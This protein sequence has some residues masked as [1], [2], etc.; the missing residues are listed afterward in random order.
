MAAFHGSSKVVDHL[1]GVRDLSWKQSQACGSAG[2]RF[3]D[4]RTDL[5][6]LYCDLQDLEEE[7]TNPKTFFKRCDHHTEVELRELLEECVEDL[8]EIEDFINALPSQKRTSIQTLDGEV[9]ELQKKICDRRNSFQDFQEQATT[10]ALE[11]MKAQLYTLV[12]DILSKR[13]PPFILTKVVDW[14]ALADELQH[15]VLVGRDMLEFD[16]GDAHSDDY[17]VIELPDSPAAGSPDPPDDVTNNDET[18]RSRKTRNLQPTVEDYV[19]GE[20]DVFYSPATIHTSPR[21]S[22]AGVEVDTLSTSLDPPE[23]THGQNPDGATEYDP[24]ADPKRKPRRVDTEMVLMQEQKSTI[25]EEIRKLKEE[26][27]ILEEQ[28]RIWEAEQ[29]RREEIQKF[30]EFCSGFPKEAEEDILA[31]CWRIPSSSFKKLSSTYA[32]SSERIPP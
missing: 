8:R 6:A 17:G 5:R 20:D 25:Q 16:D 9:S 1:K 14:D 21:S 19:E 29:K 22:V 13:R 3:N 30:R 18:P 32:A 12:D 4:I 31:E 10:T 2:P 26:A 27:E 15:P 24:L 7:L 23:N 11:T 28:K